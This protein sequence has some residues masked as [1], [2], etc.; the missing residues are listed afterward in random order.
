MDNHAH[1]WYFCAQMG[2][3]LE[4]RMFKNID[5]GV[6]QLLFKVQHH[7]LLACDPGDLICLCFRCFIYNMKTTNQPISFDYLLCS[8]LRTTQI[9]HQIHRRTKW[10]LLSFILRV[11]KKLMYIKYLE[12]RLAQRK[13]SSNVSSINIILSKEAGKD[14][15]SRA[16]VMHL[17]YRDKSKYILCACRSHNHQFIS[18]DQQRHSQEECDKMSSVIFN[19]KHVRYAQLFT[20]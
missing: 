4:L 15:A 18:G 14:I 19:V 16:N 3:A 17:S 20:C 11:S 2:R 12:Q 10:V 1:D 6:T 5:F 13:Y 7:H 9:N 8:V